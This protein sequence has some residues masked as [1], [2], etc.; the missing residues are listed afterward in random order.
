MNSATHTMLSL[1]TTAISAGAPLSITYISETT[2][3][4]GK[5]T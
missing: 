3:V 4:V 2:A 1:P 5:Y